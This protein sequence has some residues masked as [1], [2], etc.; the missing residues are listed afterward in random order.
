MPCIAV[1]EPRDQY[2]RSPAFSGGSTTNDIQQTFDNREEQGPHGIRRC[3]IGVSVHGLGG[4]QRFIVQRAWLFRRFIRAHSWMQ[5]A[6]ADPRGS[7]PPAESRLY[8]YLGGKSVIVGASQT[9]TAHLVHRHAQGIYIGRRPE[10]SS[11]QAFRRRLRMIVA[12]ATSPTTVAVCVVTSIFI[13]DRPK[14]HRTA[15]SASLTNTFA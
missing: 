9:H 14:S 2:P 12:A 10:R 13:R 1:G 5:Q 15:V 4:Q 7:H 6:L 8:E 3:R 11:H